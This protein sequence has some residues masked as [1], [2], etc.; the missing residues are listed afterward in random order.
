MCALFGPGVKIRR[1]ELDPPLHPVFP[2]LLEMAVSV[3]IAPLLE[4]LVLASPLA[5]AAPTSR[6]AEEGLMTAR[7]GAPV[8]LRVDARACPLSLPPI[9]A[10]R[11]TLPDLSLSAGEVLALPEFERPVVRRNLE[12]AKAQPVLKRAVPTRLMTAAQ[13]DAW[14]N[15]LAK[16][17]RVSLRHVALVGVFPRVPLMGDAPV[18]YVSKE[19]AISYTLSPKPAPFSTI[20]IAKHRETGEL[21]IGRFADE[22]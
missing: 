7:R 16:A 12:V 6:R 14:Q 11:R 9:G 20:V 15:R 4:P 1:V 21:L 13:A 17:K 19:A 18:Q 5:V 22:G 10:V 3:R 2:V 8:A